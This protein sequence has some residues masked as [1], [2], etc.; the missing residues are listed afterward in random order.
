MVDEARDWHEKR[1]FSHFILKAM[2][3]V[4]LLT[5]AGCPL[6]L[7]DTVKTVDGSILHGAVTSLLD[8]KLVLKTE[9]AG[10]I[11]I[12]LD[13]VVELE[14][15]EVMPIHL[16]DG[17]VIPGTI[18]PSTPGRL[19]VIR[20]EDQTRVPVV[21]SQIAAINPPPP[22]PVKWHGSLIGDLAITDGNSQTKGIGV[23]GEMSRRTAEDRITLKGGYFYSEDKGEGTRDDQ[24]ISG[25]YDYFF[26]EKLFGY[27][28]TRL[29]RDAIKD[30]ELRTTGGAGLGYQFLETDIYDLFG[31]AGI[32]Y[33]NEDFSNDPDD[34]AYAA[35]RFALGFGWWIVKDI[36]RF[37]ENAEFL[38]SVEDTND[39]LGIS[40]TSLIWKWTDQWSSRAGIRFEYDNTPATG[41]ERADTK[42]MLGIGYTF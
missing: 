26:T 6:A 23:A 11:I 37:E 36:V 17:T 3:F 8:G 4:G 38:L 27:L 12:P 22:P 14:T 32:S 13:K 33:V 2:V 31:E 20:A 15:A 9:F 16:S 34:Q 10:E 18:Q 19:E 28:N 42:Y 40:E 25:K 5:W 21:P 41:F 35:A 7:P 39:W 30:L 29:D 1:G 24:F